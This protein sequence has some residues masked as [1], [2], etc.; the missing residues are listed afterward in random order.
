[1]DAWVPGLRVAGYNSFMKPDRH[2]PPSCSPFLQRLETRYPA[3]R[4]S[5]EQEGRLS[6]DSPP[7]AETLAQSIAEHGLDP[8]LRRFRNREMLRITWRELAGTATLEQTLADLS[9]LAELCVQA[10]LEA[11]RRSLEERHG[12]PRDQDGNALQL[13]VLAL[14]KLGGREL[15]LSSDID[16]IL[17]FPSTGTC[18]GQRAL[19]NEQFFTRQARAM[20]AS[21]AEHTEDGFCF[22]VDTRLRP[23]G[24]S[25][26]LVCSFGALENYYQ[27][28]G[29]DWERY[30]LLKA[31]PIAGDRK[32][33][34]GLLQDLTPFVYRRYIDFGAVE[35][36]HAMLD[37]IRTDAARRDRGNDVKRGPGGIRE[38]EFLVQCLQLQR[39]GRE[40]AL[41]TPFLREALR[42][43]EELDLFPAQRLQSVRDSYAFL[44]HLENA[45]QAQQDQQ[46]H[47]LPDG[48][49]LLRITA[50]MGYTSPGELL[51]ALDKTRKAVSDAL[52]ESFPRQAAPPSRTGAWRERAEEMPAGFIDNL[53]R[54]SPGPRAWERLDQFM[55]LLLRALDARGMLAERSPEQTAEQHALARDACR[56]VFELVQSISRR[57][58]YLALLIQNPAALER[59]LDL[60][61][62]SDWVAKTVVRHPALLDELLDPELG[63]E[64]PGRETL[65]PATER[66]TARGDDEGHIHDLN[67][68]KLAQSLRIAVAELD[69]V[70][71]ASHAETL[72]T[73]L[74]EVLLEAL[75]SLSRDMLAR[76]HPAPTSANG[77]LII[78]YGSLGA[79]DVSY[80][81]DLDLVFLYPKQPAN[82][83]D[84]PAP[85]GQGLAPET[86][87]TR[88]VRRLLAI[89]TTTT[90]AG[91]LYE[92]DT[93]LR[94]NGRS[95]L[96]VSPMAA[97]ERYQRDKA[98][99]W[100][101]QALTRARPVAGNTRLGQRFFELREAVLSTPR[102]LQ[103]L[104]KEVADMRRRMRTQNPG[105]DPLKHGPGGLL[106]MDFVAQLGVLEMAPQDAQLRAATSTRKQLELL[107]ALGW[108][109]A[110]HAGVLI[111]TH[112]ALTRARHQKALCRDGCL[113]VPDTTEAAALCARYGIG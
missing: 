92:V 69:G 62:A 47:S 24:E 40:P 67:Y 37:A 74:A 87:Y 13:V 43:I 60:F 85:D 99:T 30:A 29:R 63:R 6:G 38:V 16:L 28:E 71:S 73:Q 25:G 33:G 108:L 106:D 97:F 49:A 65:R 59:M 84:A 17:C 12:K 56:D 77:L 98:W 61:V 41:R 86:W 26:A 18:D 64:L 48:D 100:E 3:W 90:A 7:A 35:S 27:R 9:T 102:D 78:G 101:W 95:G 76:R 81:S 10:A 36:L 32:A 14:G 93:R 58:A 57:S 112:H 80:A 94:P 1:M 20:I 70:I 42:A 103:S 22:R 21:L 34:A 8:G 89:A 51:D 31:R 52:D 91:R 83:K 53:Q 82:P 79:G 104:R 19:S 107:G 45:I 96:L 44:R 54:R 4:P 75:L 110:D 113:E 15:N 109:E 68:L 111:E 55:P 66:L 88:Q 105:G 72:L 2:D 23:F 46:T 11:H 5:L 39:G 50:V